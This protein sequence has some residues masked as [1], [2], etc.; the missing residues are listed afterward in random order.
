MG[1]LL[2][3]PGVDYGPQAGWAGARILE[4]AKVCVVAYPFDVTVT[5]ARDGDHS[6]PLDPHHTGDAFDFRTHDLPTG[7][8]AR[9]LHDLALG[10]GPRFYA[11]LEDP[12]VPNEHIH[13]QRAKGTTYTALDYLRNA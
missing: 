13:V 8:A 6:G 1:R 5:S 3:K 7:G 10:L 12:G 4:V 9:F 11:F 2:T